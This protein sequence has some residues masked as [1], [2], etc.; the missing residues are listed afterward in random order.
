MM[1]RMVTEGDNVRVIAGRYRLEARLGRGGMG[2]VWRATDQL[3]GTGDG[4]KAD[5]PLVK[6]YGEGEAEQ[7][8]RITRPH[9]ES[10][11]VSID[12]VITTGWT[13]TEGGI[14]TFTAPPAVG[15]LVRAGFTFDVPVRFAEDKLEVSGAVSAAGEVPS[16]PVIE[17]REATP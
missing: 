14:V 6:T 16:V 12:G 5:F 2:V 15:K 17:V 9:V 13:L 11:M 1:G 4:I 8:R 3:L 10:I 7:A